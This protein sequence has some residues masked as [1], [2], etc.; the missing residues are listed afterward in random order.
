MK[1]IKIVA[2]LCV[3]LFLLFFSTFLVFPSEVS[4]NSNVPVTLDEVL[5]KFG[6]LYIGFFPLKQAEIKRTF[7]HL[8]VSYMEA[9]TF[10]VKFTNGIYGVTSNGNLILSS[11]NNFDLVA[12]FESSNYNNT[13]R[14]FLF[15]LKNCALFGSIKAVEFYNK[16]IAFRDNNGISVIIG[17]EDFMIKLEEYNKVIN[18]FKSDIKKIQTIDLR[19]NLQAVVKWR[20]NG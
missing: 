16:D 2:I 3:S 12:N 19:F 11:Q 10:F 14:A 5:R 7:F 13:V 8:D 6:P 4:Y 9:S 1:K 15:A 20:D 17:K 18:L